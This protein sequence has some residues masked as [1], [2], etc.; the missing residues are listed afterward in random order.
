MFARRIFRPV[1]PQVVRVNVNSD[2]ALS[3]P[4]TIQERLPRQ[5]LNQI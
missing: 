5:N 4:Y 3:Q 2:N 1:I